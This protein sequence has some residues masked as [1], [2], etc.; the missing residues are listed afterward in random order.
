MTIALPNEIIISLLLLL[1]VHTVGEY[2]DVIYIMRRVSSTYYI[3][4]VR[5][6]IGYRLDLLLLLT[7]FAKG[8]SG[9]CLVGRLTFGLVT[10]S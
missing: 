2:V 7:E 5:L 8:A 6:S 9:Q 3:G 4:T 1:T 10:S